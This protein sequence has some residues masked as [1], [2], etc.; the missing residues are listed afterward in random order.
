[1]KRILSMVLAAIGQFLF[2]TLFGPPLVTARTRDVAIT[3]RMGI[4]FP[5]DVNRAHPASILPGLI[6]SA[7]PL[8]AYGEAALFGTGS[9]YRAVLAADQSATAQKI[10]G[11]L[12]RPY[13]TQQSSGGSSAS[14][15]AATPP[16]SGVAD[17][18]HQGFIM[19]KG[20]A[21]MT[22]KKGDPCYIW[23]IATSGANIQGEFQA[24]A[25]ANSTVLCSNA[26]YNGPADANGNVEIE[27]WASN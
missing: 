27:V 20:K 17:F 19:V 25:T 3:Y 16:Q 9:N 26:R 23:A 10:A 21:G 4:G 7:N 18:M 12:V 22:V 13:P 14:F 8:R 1:M 5:G 6:D 24:A 11:V 2:N 15:G